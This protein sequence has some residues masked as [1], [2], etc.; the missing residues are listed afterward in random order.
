MTTQKR[1]RDREDRK[2]WIWSGT[3]KTNQLTWHNMQGNPW[4]MS[5]AGWLAYRREKDAIQAETRGSPVVP[6]P[7]RPASPEGGTTAS[8]PR[9]WRTG[10]GKPGSM[11][12][13]SPAVAPP[14]DVKALTV[15]G[16][17][18]WGRRPVEEGERGGGTSGDG[19][20]GL[21]ANI[22]HLTIALLVYKRARKTASLKMT[23]D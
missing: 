1:N 2:I 21:L 17:R 4:N 3:N 22:S 8:P 10:L 15:M 11:R 20:M 5:E 9:R 16:G 14:A 18:S 7:P 12:A 6:S 23:L 19:K 13:P